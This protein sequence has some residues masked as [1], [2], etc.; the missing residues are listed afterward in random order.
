MAS[1]KGAYC[2]CTE[3]S[4]CTKHRCRAPLHMV[5][6]SLMRPAVCVWGCPSSFI[7]TSDADD[8]HIHRIADSGCA[9]LC[10]VPC[11]SMTSVAP[12]LECSRS[13]FWVIRASTQPRCCSLASPSCAALGWMSLNS[14]QPAHL[15]CSCHL[16]WLS[17]TESYRITQ[18]AL[19][20][21]V[22]RAAWYTR[23]VR[24]LRG[25]PT[26]KAAGPVSLL[27]L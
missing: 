26:C 3:T 13:T 4:I 27:G 22:M 17:P 2:S 6:C 9:Y 1:S 20:T 23:L 7:C 11:S 18:L 10:V 19:S 15:P 14:C 5:P 12:A 16:R 8:N 21:V 25:W 24:W